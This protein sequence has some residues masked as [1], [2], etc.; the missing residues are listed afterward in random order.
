MNLELIAGANDRQLNINTPLYTEVFQC[1]TSA[2]I[3]TNSLT[4]QCNM[5]ALYTVYSNILQ[6]DPG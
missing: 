2:F 1:D 4:N 3:Y 6:T 5:I